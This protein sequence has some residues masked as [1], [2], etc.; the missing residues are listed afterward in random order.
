MWRLY[1]I[2]DRAAAQNRELAWIAERAIQGG[3][4]AIQLRHKTASA[5][6]LIEEA[7]QL[8]RVTRA[9]KIPLLINDRVDV[10]AAV[11]AAGVHLGQDDLPVSAARRLLGPAGIIG[12]STHSLQQ[13]L[14]AEQEGVD[15]LAVGP[16]Y[17]TPTKPDAIHVGVGLIG[18]VTARVRRPLVMIGGVDRTTLPE[19]VA[20]GAICVAVVRAVCQAEDPKAAAEELKGILLRKIS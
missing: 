2:V 8:L 10:A 7:E 1:V 17:P 5:R 3:A 18:Q 13:A 15:Y 9:S 16:I 20:A 14:D 11:G 12:K 4:D 6:Q 19:V